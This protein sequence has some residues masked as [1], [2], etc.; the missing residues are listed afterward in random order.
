MI[1]KILFFIQRHKFIAALSLAVFIFIVYVSYQRISNNAS[2]TR[3]ILARVE[4]ATIVSYVSGSGQVT[5]SNQLDLKPKVSAEIIYLPIKEGTWVKTGT[6]IAQLDYTDAEK[7]V[8]DAQSNLDA[9][10]LA[11]RKL[12]EPADTLSLLQAENA[13]AAA[14]EA[15][16]NAENDLLKS[17]DNGFNTV[18][19]AFL[20][21]SP[22]ITG[23]N[24][25]LYGTELSVGGQSNVA[26][27]ADSVK[28]YDIKALAYKD[29]ASNAYTLARTKYDKN[30]QDYKSLSRFSDYDAIGA[31][32]NETYDTARSVGEAIKNSNTLIQFYEDRLTEHNLRP[33]S[34][35]DTHI[36]SLT[37]YTGKI[38]TAIL[39]LLAVKNTI[40]N[41][42]QAIISAQRA[43]AEKTESLKKLKK[44]TDDLDIESQ[45]LTIQQRTNTLLDAKDK[46][47]HYFLY[48]PFDGVVAK[49]NVK[50]GDIASG[51][52]ALATFITQQKIAE[53]SMNEIDVAKVKIGDRAT[54]TFDALQSLNITGAVAEIDTI[55]TTAQGVVSYVVKI[56][57][58]TQDN[59]VKPGMTV[60]ASI[61]TDV[62]TDALAVPNAAIKSQNNESYVEMPD[63]SEISISAIDTN[64][65]VI[66]TKP[67]Y[68]QIVEIGISNDDRTE[69]ITGLNEGDIIIARTINVPITISSQQSSSL[70]VPGLPGGG[71][72]GIR[73]SGVGR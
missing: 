27:Y 12:K 44:G 23:L 11:M 8:R 48:A 73:G 13:L 18:A 67:T 39:N 43:I 57:F 37:T 5:V 25:I 61:I 7:A 59:R 38:N 58:D 50:K 1:K 21:L 51:A 42:K 56:A 2:P 70:R 46:L 35:A 45:Q 72:G 14:E 34:L 29:D 62:K 10:N 15:E 3:Y 4:R 26:Y 32:I 36:V 19:N 20:D 69:I 64:I 28:S 6:L 53:I 55:G 16:I 30:F 9:A 17:Y 66:L 65:G 49:I 31:L 40:D 60:S 47:A 22:T 54:L 33:N 68:R 41:Y 63:L 52:T 24:T 71:S